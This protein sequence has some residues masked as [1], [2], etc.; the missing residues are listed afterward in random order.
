MIGVYEM[1]Y[2]KPIFI[3]V[4]ILIIS[5]FFAGCDVFTTP[6][7]ARGNIS[8]RVLIPQ[9]TKNITNDISG[10]IPVAHATVTIVDANGISHTV[11]T[12][13]NGY[14]TFTN[15]EVNSNTIITANVTVN[16]ETLILKTVIPQAVAAN[17]DY[18][19]G[20][21]TPESTALALVAEKLLD[22][23]I[24]PEDINI[25]EIKNTDNFNN[26]KEQISSVLEELGN[27]TE[28]STINS[29]VDNTADKIINPPA[30]SAAPI[31]PPSPSVIPPFFAVTGVRINQ[32]DET[33][34]IGGTHKLSVTITPGYA[35]YKKVT[36]SSDNES[37]ATVSSQGTVTA[38]SEGTAIITVTTVSGN[39]TDTITITVSKIYNQTKN[40]SYETIQNAIDD[41]DSGDIIIVGVGTYN[42]AIS[43]D[44]S[45]TLL[46]AQVGVD[47]RNRNG[48][49]TIIDP[50]DPSGGANKS[51]VIRVR[52]SN[53]TIEGFTIQNPSLIYGSAGLIDITGAWN[54]IQ[55][56][57]NIFQNPGVRTSNS[58][59]WGKF[60]I[61]I[62]GV[63]NVRVENN[64]FRNILC[65]TA[66]PWNGTAAIWPSGSSNI[67]ILNNR[68]ENITT[69]GVGLSGNNSNVLIIG[70]EISLGGLGGTPSWTRSGIRVGMGNDNINIS[71]NNISNCTGTE[72]ASAG[73]R[74]QNTATTT[75]EVSGN[76][77]SN[78]NIGIA[79]EPDANNFDITGNTFSNIK[80]LGG[81]RWYNIYGSYEDLEA[82]LENNSFPDGSEV[83][84]N[85][86]N[87][88]EQNI[89]IVP[90]S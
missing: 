15:I 9:G 28:D 62:E 36:W 39:K 45:L 29:L 6:S 84:P 22:E 80:V 50:N 47:A 37:V 7:P 88:E 83:Q 65:D 27:V 44:K 69:Y 25:D 85:P 61:N 31:A 48:D 33:L 78:I 51:W 19:I 3:I 71:N 1:K 5:C 63:S 14:Y 43:I 2:N 70:N 56:K 77:V 21:M 59:N 72:N 12:D 38:V 58:T 23:G 57:N 67:E 40:T 46:G 55:I 20:S 32:E 35:T 79:I 34:V 49:E 86:N 4:V 30:P 73:I 68:I 41:A 87:P 81:Y 16:G 75:T 82:V 89:I 76:I 26:L 54:N 66:T 60:G 8:G 24:S 74:L 53:V 11:T 52:A 17:E 42:E 13:K 18:D 10:W 64:Y 90:G